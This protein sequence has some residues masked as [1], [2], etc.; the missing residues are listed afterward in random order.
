MAV[1]CQQGNTQAT[2]RECN[3]C[4]NCR[5]TWVEEYTFDALKV[6]QVKRSFPRKGLTDGFEA[7]YAFPMSIGVMPPPVHA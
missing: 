4:H 2:F 6:F 1:L 3:F 5:D 7:R